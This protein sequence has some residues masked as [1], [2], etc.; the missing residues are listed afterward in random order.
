MY[1]KRLEFPGN[2]ASAALTVLCA[3]DL[4]EDLLIEGPRAVCTKERERAA[5]TIIGQSHPVLTFLH[6]SVDVKCHISVVVDSVGVVGDREG[7]FCLDG[8]SALPL[9]GLL[10][11]GLHLGR[12]DGEVVVVGGIIVS[13]GLGVVRRLVVTSSSN[14]KDGGG[15]GG[16]R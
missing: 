11:W 3:H 15:G 8:E 12:H 2:D 10:C 14:K 13:S 4:A 7:V 9:G 5:I 6:H 16:T 1:F